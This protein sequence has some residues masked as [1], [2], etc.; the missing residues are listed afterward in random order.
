MLTLEE[1]VAAA[2]VLGHRITAEHDD[3][4]GAL[5]ITVHA[6]SGQV[7]GT[8]V[9]LV[10]PAAVVEDERPAA[11]RAN[12]EAVSAALRALL[13]QAGIELAVVAMAERILAEQE[14]AGD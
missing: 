14:A 4:A 13:D 10:D 3:S 7:H 5:A 12:A 8:F 2:E 6:G 1:L 11:E 9:S